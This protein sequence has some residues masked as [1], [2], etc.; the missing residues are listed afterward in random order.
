MDIGDHASVDE[1]P[2]ITVPFAHLSGMVVD[3][4]ETQDEAIAIFARSAA[5][6][7]VCPDCGWRSRSVH[8][9]YRRRVADTPLGGRPVGI[10]VEVRRFACA[11]ADC[12]RRT[13]VEQVPGV[14]V[15]RGRRSVS[16]SRMLH[17]VAVT[18]AGRA[19]ARLAA[20]LS[21][22]V[23]RST[24]IRLLRA[25]PDPAAS[26][27]PRVLGVDDFA[28]RRGQVYATIL[29]NMDTHRPVE[30][31]PDREASTLAGWLSAHPGIEIICRDRGG[32]YADGARTGAPDA[33]QV[34]DRWHL[35]HNLGE[36][37]YTTVTAHRGDLAEPPPPADTPDSG[38]PPLID[39]PVV[40]QTRLAVRTRERYAD[41]QGL[42]AEGVSRS[43]ISRRLG[44]DRQTVRRFADATSVDHLLAGS[45]RDNP[46]D[47]YL[48][49]LNDRFNAGCTTASVL[50]AEIRGRGFR[51][52]VQTV[53]RYLAPFRGTGTAPPSAPPVVK[54]RHATR[55]IMTDP[56]KILAADRRR[57]DEIIARSPA[58]G[59][60]AEHV[61]GFAHMMVG[62]HGHLLPDWIAG[63]QADDLPAMRSFANGLHRDLAAV[64]NGLTLPYSS[65]AVEGNVNRII[66]WN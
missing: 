28:L 44:L 59:R 7:A 15:R 2:L 31:L 40:A 4:V 30:V 49:Y 33:I 52:G 5:V 27:A 12:P 41:V 55:W 50:H 34:A 58:L 39:P 54:A 48:P 14:T 9:R 6:D 24:L 1:P 32:A 65:G 51:G 18:V 16:L 63:V 45:R 37:V 21:V 8:L 43:A 60:L 25:G 57:L 23:S 56:D 53:R 26:G 20:R 11:N 62:L 22:S 36:A 38:A 61:R 64:T 29:I 10:M 46:L 13:F 17:A 35:W 19:G 66:L 3:R 47:E 42:L